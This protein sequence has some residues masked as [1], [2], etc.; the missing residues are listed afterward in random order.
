LIL[1][2]PEW[3]SSASTER[4]AIAASLAKKNIFRI[5]PNEIRRLLADGHHVNMEKGN[6]VSI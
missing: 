3:G 6:Q 1:L 4:N 2:F 5:C